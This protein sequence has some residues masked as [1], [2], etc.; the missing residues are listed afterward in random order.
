MAGLLLENVKDES[1]PKFQKSQFMGLMRQL[2]DG[3][4]IVEGNQ[5]VENHEWSTANDTTQVDVKGK[6]RATEIFH[7][8]GRSTGFPSISR[9]GVGDFESSAAPQENP[10]EEHSFVEDAN[11]AYFRQENTEYTRY[12]TIDANTP[13]AHT[14]NLDVASWDKLQN[15]WDNF[16]ATASG[17]RPVE[18][19]QFQDNNPYLIGDS[20]KTYHHAMHNHQSIVEV[21][22]CQSF[23]YQSN[24][25]LRASWNWKLLYKE[26]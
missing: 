22:L 16:E 4:V 15:D 10:A 20:S 11:D 14:T 25:Y 12:W 13:G 5:V 26:I 18:S 17:I 23:L 9:T 7:N 21:R 24:C 1:N 19:Y 8:D 3:K 2:R 6:G